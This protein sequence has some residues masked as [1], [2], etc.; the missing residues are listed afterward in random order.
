MGAQNALEATLSPTHSQTSTLLLSQTPIPSATPF[1][2]NTQKP[3]S[4]PIKPDSGWVSLRS[5]LERRM[6]NILDESGQHLEALYLLRINPE[7]F[8]FR[9]EYQTPPKTLGDW[10]KDTGALILVNGGYFR[11]EGDIYIPTGL[12]IINGQVIGNTY[13][14]YAGMLGIT[15]LGP[16][17]RWMA[18]EPYTPGE[19]IESA[20]QSFPLLIKPGGV[21]GFPRQNEDYKQARRSVIGRDFEGRFVL[22]VASHGIFTLHQLSLFLAE[23]DL[24]LDIALNLDGGP[25]SGILLA[26]PYEEIQSL[27]PLPVII[28][29]YTR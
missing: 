8:L 7:A 21:L 4:T 19:S 24:N 3:T 12:T 26:D 28:A 16:E 17:L 5:G 22:I 13:G 15:D 2:T 9:I 6:I 27:S 25:S 18:Q 20:L 29:V 1:P 10:Q 23:S 14:D 11:V